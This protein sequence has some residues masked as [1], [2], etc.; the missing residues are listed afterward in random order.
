MYNMKEKLMCFRMPKEIEREIEKFALEKDK[1]KSKLMSELL[2]LGI[3]EMRIMKSLKLYSEGKI[4]LWRASRIADVSLWK[5][6]EI[7]KENKIPLQYGEKELKEDLKAL[8][9]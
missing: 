9:E 7:I 2:L 1:D 3:K 6:I 4:T 8:E 5:M